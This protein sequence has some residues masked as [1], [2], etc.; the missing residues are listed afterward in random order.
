MLKAGVKIYEYAPTFIH[1]K[2]MVVDG[3]WSIIGSPNLNYRSRQLDEENAFG[4]LDRELAN[5][6]VSIFRADVEDATEI[7]LDEWRRRSVLLRMV[8]HL[9]QVLDKQS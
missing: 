1:S 8:Q 3:S 9:A 6:L 7:K 5:Q 2:F 4:I